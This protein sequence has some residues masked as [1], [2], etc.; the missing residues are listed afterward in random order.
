[1]RKVIAGT[2]VSLDGVMQAPG[3]PEEDAAGGFTLGG[4]TVP[5]FDDVVGAAMHELFAPPY[6][7][8]LGRKTYDIFAAYWPQAGDGPDGEIA[9]QFNA[10]TKYVATSSR[11]PLAWANSVALHDPVADVARLKQEDGPNLVIQG[12]S[13]L[14][15]ALHGAGLIDRHTLLVFPVVLGSGKRVFGAGVKP[16]ALK[17]VAAQTAPSGVVISTLEPAGAVQTGSF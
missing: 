3:G 8:L 4:W 2:F 5:Y 12:S 6:D 17:L 7:L 11:A 15:A 16:A 10:A 9:R 1:M 13:V 14:I